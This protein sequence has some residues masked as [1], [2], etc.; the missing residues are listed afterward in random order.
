MAGLL[1]WNRNVLRFDLNK[2]RDSFCG[3]GRGRSFNI[4]GRKMEKAWEPT[5]ESLIRES[6][7]W[8]IVGGLW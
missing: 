7:K 2:S 4:E 3:R 1:F 6:T 8:E 5:V